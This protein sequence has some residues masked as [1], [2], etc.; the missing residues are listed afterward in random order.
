MKKVNP[1]TVIYTDRKIEEVIAERGIYQDI[2]SVNPNTEKGV[3]TN[4]QHPYGTDVINEWGYSE[5]IWSHF[6]PIGNGKTAAMVAGGI[7]TEVVQIN[8]DT[9]WDG[10]PYG[11]LTD[12]S[13]NVLKTLEGIANAKTITVTNLTGGSRQDGWK[14]FRGADKNGNPAPIGSANAFVGDERF[15]NDY[16]DF[17]RESISNQAMETDNSKTAVA[18][19]NRYS[20]ER[21]VEKSFLG[22]PYRQRSY[23]SFAE[24][25]LDFGHD[26]KNATNYVKSLDLETGI[27]TVEYDYNGCHFKREYFAS[28]PKNVIAM[29]ISSEKELDFNARLHTY[30]AQN[31]SYCKYEKISDNEVKVTA[32]VTDMNTDNGEVGTVNA[33]KFEARM[34]IDANASFRVSE[35]NTT[36]FVTGGTTAQIYVVGATNYVDYLN[37][38]N[39]K[40][41]RECELYLNKVKSNTYDEIKSE[42]IKDFTELFT[43][44]S[45]EIENTDACDCSHLATE[46]R[47]RKDINGK[48]GFLSGV[49]PSLEETN[50]NGVI[51]SYSSGDNS[52]A[53]LEFNFGKYML[54]SGSRPKCQPLNLTGKW[55]AALA[56]LWNGKYT[57]NINTEM[58][59]WAAQPLNLGECE[60]PLLDTI[61]QLAKSGAITAANQYAIFNDRGDDQFLPGDPWVMHHNFDLWRGTQPID[62]ATAGLW[63]TGGLWLLEHAWQ[64]Y[65]FNKDTNYLREMYPYMCGAARF[66]VQ[67]VVLDTKT[68]YLITAAS[69]SPEQGGVQPGPAMDT[70]LIRNLYDMVI[71]ANEILKEDD[72][73]LICKIKSQMPQNYFANEKGKIA[74]N[75]IDEYGFVEEWA[76]GDVCF[77]FAKNGDNGWELKNPFT[78]EVKTVYEHSAGNKT[79]HKHC[80]HLWEV[81]PGTHLNAYSAEQA[82]LYHAFKK[83]LEIRGAGTTGWSLAWR[84]CLAARVLDGEKASEMLEQLLTTRTAPNM[85]DE[86]PHFQ[87]DG[88]FGVTAGIIEMLVQSHNGEISLLPALPKKWKNGKIKGINTRED[89]LVDVE[90]ENGKVKQAVIYAKADRIFNIRFKGVNDAV[91]FE[92]D[93]QIQARFTSNDEVLAFSGKRNKKYVVILR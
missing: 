44:T 43:R 49:S 62:I 25:Y 66:F 70:Q 87:A 69:C 33:I 58:N 36:V 22:T 6:Y 29:R 80:S 83:S 52:L 53:V 35:D 2:L 42:H 86:H 88:N 45:L 71:R 32:F 81:Y 17:A 14:Y 92:N 8:E 24:V 40:P 3:N 76:R 74:P 28:Y 68:G 55:N 26:S 7:D 4:I 54:I 82:E 60:L 64:Y 85:F 89:A 93:T 37:L 72:A 67:Y 59:Y 78:G 65:R 84:M 5:Y 9:C 18:A 47:V 63:P 75:L 13:G 30:H 91:V 48:S 11:I 39:S 50:A 21:M 27:I 38:D 15:R 31:T 16:P 23:K 57:I 90:W 34:Y 77:D 41:E 79:N 46:K 73:D 1:N 10:S 61:A 20:M 19:Q 12:E 51:S 56:P